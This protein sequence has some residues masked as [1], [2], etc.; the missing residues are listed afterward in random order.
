MSV[1]PNRHNPM[2][3]P[4]YPLHGPPRNDEEREL[5]QSY[6]RAEQ[7]EM[8]AKVQAKLS[9]PK[10]LQQA[11][12]E[13][14]ADLKWEIHQ[15]LRNRSFLNSFTNSCSDKAKAFNKCL[16][17]QTEFLMALRFHKMGSDQDREKVIVKADQMYLAQIKNERSE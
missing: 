11:A 12:E 15:C 6:I 1:P 16:Q 13:N 7:N 14:C 3:N 8:Y 2:D 17:I 10:S 5:I 4:F 9:K